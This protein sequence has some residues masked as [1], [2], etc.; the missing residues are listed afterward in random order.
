MS[1]FFVHVYFYS[2]VPVPTNFLLCTHTRA[3]LHR[4]F[5]ILIFVGSINSGTKLL[6]INK[7]LMRNSATSCHLGQHDMHKR[8]YQ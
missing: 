2:H 1:L 5:Q 6:V 7:W 3:V 8:E 4:I